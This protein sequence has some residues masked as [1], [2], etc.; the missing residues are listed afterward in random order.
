H[1][2]AGDGAARGRSVARRNRC[3]PSG[4]TTPLHA[5][6]VAADG[7]D[8]FHRRGIPCVWRASSDGWLA[9]LETDRVERTAGACA[10]EFHRAG[11]RGTR[12]AGLA[13]RPSRC[14]S[15]TPPTTF[16]ANATR[17]HG[18]MSRAR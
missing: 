15:A 9:Q 2:R 7:V 16:C 18:T 1:V 13:E 14:L 6:V 17:F 5:L 8:R 11:A 12:G 4:K 3:E 10:A